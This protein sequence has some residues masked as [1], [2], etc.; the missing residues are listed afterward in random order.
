[1]SWFFLTIISPFLYAIT[2]H[3]DKIL[4]EKYFKNG[5]VGVLVLIS[6]LL[7]ALSLPFL[8]FADPTVL[9]TS[10]TNIVIL[11]LIGIMGV[12]ITWSYLMA[13][14]GDEA[15]ITV[16]FYQLIPVLGVILGYF[17]LDE[18]LT[19][20]QLIAMAIIILGTS[21]ISFE[22][23][24]DN[25]F[26]LRR[27]TI[28]YMLAASTMEAICSVAFKY[29]A[30]EETVVT[31]L[32]WTFFSST[33]VGICIFIFVGSY[34]KNLIQALQTNSKKIISL[35]FLNETLYMLAD[36]VFAFAYLM[37]PIALVLIVNSFQPIFVVLIGIF[38][39]IF[40]PNFNVL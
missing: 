10:I 7:S 36:M 6:S 17:V 33:L 1:M 32:F 31:S 12:S 20:L 19:K 16:I 3:I 2:N 21:I 9:H 27:Q 39:N 8:F 38:L 26:T 22:I 14:E 5:G 35:N 18:V 15:S 34:R 37:A 4:L 40:F 28:F 25:N 23:D 29:V 11:T 24:A 30:L 13:L